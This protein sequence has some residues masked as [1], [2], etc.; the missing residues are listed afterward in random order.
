MA[1][2]CGYFDKEVEREEPNKPFVLVQHPYAPSQFRVEF[3]LEKEGDPVLPP[4]TNETL[5]VDSLGW[6]S[7]DQGRRVVDYLN[8]RW[9]TGSIDPTETN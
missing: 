7:L 8:S 3:L 2:V 9:S 4:Y 6:M 1:V 5:G